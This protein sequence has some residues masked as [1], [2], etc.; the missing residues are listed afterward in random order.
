MAGKRSKNINTRIFFIQLYY[1][2]S[3]KK[4]TPFSS[5]WILSP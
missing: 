1:N 4:E 5:C 2:I 3:L